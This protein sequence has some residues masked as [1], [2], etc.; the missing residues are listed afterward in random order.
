VPEY[1]ASPTL[2][3]QVFRSSVSCMKEQM[4]LQEARKILADTRSFVGVIQGDKVV[5]DGSFKPREL[6]ALLFLMR[7]HP[8]AP[9]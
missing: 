2:P 9:E 4:T 6:E 8:T 5:L 3:R 7:N 1:Q